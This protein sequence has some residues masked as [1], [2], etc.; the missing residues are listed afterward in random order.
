MS[1]TRV[2]ARLGNSRTSKRRKAAA[3][4]SVPTRRSSRIRGVAADD[5]YV[6]NEG[7]GGKIEIGGQ[8]STMHELQKLRENS[9]AW[10]EKK[11]KKDSRL[12]DGPLTL[13]S[14]GGTEVR[15]D[16]PQLPQRPRFSR[17]SDASAASS[18]PRHSRVQRK[19]LQDV[20]VGRFCRKGVP[21]RIYS[22]TTFPSD[23]LL[24]AAGDKS[25]NLGLWSVDDDSQASEGTDGVVL[26]K[27]HAST[28]NRLA[29]DHEPHKLYSFSYD[30]SVRYMDIVKGVFDQ[31]CASDGMAATCGFSTAR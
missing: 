7:R 18:I 9:A 2:I 16:V 31:S 30:G 17:K 12:P 22:I 24:V 26:Y 6:V 29:F 10:D 4:S 28:I 23:A 25:G 3:K 27:P 15:R 11:K 8:P 13:E 21:D 5:V 14:T 19:T 1:A 20:D